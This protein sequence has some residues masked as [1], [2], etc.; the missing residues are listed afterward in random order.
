MAQMALAF[1]LTGPHSPAEFADNAGAL[2]V[3]L[4]AEESAWLDLETTERPF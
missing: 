3:D 4:S 2:E 1:T